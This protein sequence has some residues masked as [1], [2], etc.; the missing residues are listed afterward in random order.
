MRDALNKKI[1]LLK[2]VRISLPPFFMTLSLGLQSDT[3]QHS[4][5]VYL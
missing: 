1:F 5:V 3:M 4:C 2:E